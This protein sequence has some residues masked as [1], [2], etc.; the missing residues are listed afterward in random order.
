MWVY[1]DLVL[2]CLGI[3]GR[4]VSRTRV[5]AT[6]SWLTVPSCITCGTFTVAVYTHVICVQMTKIFIRELSQH[7]FPRFTGRTREN[8]AEEKK[9]PEVSHTAT[10]ALGCSGTVPLL[11]PELFKARKHESQ[12]N[13]LI[14]L[15]T[16]LP[17]TPQCMHIHGTAWSVFQH[18]E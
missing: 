16:D 11:R 2:S 15:A 14:V 5:A 17:Q 6:T 4:E 3:W 8:R 10:L 9:L 13:E 1:R 7:H 12:K 18:A